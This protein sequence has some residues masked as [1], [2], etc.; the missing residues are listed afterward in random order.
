MEKVVAI[1][2]DVWGDKMETPMVNVKLHSET[3]VL[4]QDPLL[5]EADLDTKIRHL[6]ETEYLRRFAR[7]KRTDHI[8]MQKYGMDFVQFLNDHITQQADYRWEVEKDA[9]DWETATGGMQTM[10]RKLA[11]LRSLR[12]DDAN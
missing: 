12:H 6:L 8:L 2:T 10:E 9:M 7:Y 1:P 5:G 4:L 3:E 11:E